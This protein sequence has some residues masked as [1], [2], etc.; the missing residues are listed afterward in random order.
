[1]HQRAATQTEAD[2]IAADLASDCVSTLRG[3]GSLLRK[4]DGKGALD[5]WL[6]KT[7]LNR[8]LTLRRIRKFEMRFMFSETRRYFTLET[9]NILENESPEKAL[10]SLIRTSLLKAL[11]TCSA[12]ERLMLR[13]VYCEGVTQRELGQMWE[14][15]E[16]KMSRRLSRALDR[17]KSET[18]R[19][20]G[21]KDPSVRITWNDFLRL[22]DELRLQLVSSPSE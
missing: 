11:S 21:L 13:L 16:C 9:L 2:D 12:E 6:R 8:F 19:Q 15:R 4:Y 5:G 7:A 22:A 18:L 10:L 1:L 17:I 20:I 3:S 14:W